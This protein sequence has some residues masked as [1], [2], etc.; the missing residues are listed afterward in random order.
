MAENKQIN[1]FKILQD[2]MNFLLNNIKRPIS[3]NVITVIKQPKRL[4]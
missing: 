3:T 1:M 2:K 4:A